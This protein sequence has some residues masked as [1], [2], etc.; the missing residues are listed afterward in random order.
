[1]ATKHPIRISERE[2]EKQKKERA[3]FRKFGRAAGSELSVNMQSIRSRLPPQPDI[4]CVSTS[5]GPYRFELCELADTTMKQSRTDSELTLESLVHEKRLDQLDAARV[6]T[7]YDRCYVN[8]GRPTKNV[9]IVL[10]AIAHYMLRP[11]VQPPAA[12]APSLMVN[13]RHIPGT[14]SERGLVQIHG[15][16]SCLNEPGARWQVNSGGSFND[17]IRESIGK[18]ADRTYSLRG[19]LVKPQLLLYYDGD[20]QYMESFPCE[21]DVLSLRNSWGTKF[22]DVWVFDADESRVVM[23]PTA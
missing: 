10:A 17:C 20:P 14:L 4:Y 8:I 11:D 19:T 1:M 15:P 9:R 21:F 6:D 22:T 3:I 13:I 5:H 12:G 2:R 7:K 18:K 23:H 16:M